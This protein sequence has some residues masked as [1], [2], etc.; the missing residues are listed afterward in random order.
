[1]EQTTRAKRGNE[2]GVDIH[3]QHVSVYIH[4]PICA[5]CEFHLCN[6]CPQSVKSVSS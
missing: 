3:S 5:I 1:M 6:L 4:A 2:T